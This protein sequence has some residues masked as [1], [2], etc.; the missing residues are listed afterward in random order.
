M[1]PTQEDTTKEK[2]KLPKKH[3]FGLS[4]DEILSLKIT[5]IMTVITFFLLY[6]FLSAKSEL[7]IA[8]TAGAIGG[9]LHEFVQSKGKVL[10]IQQMEDGL[11]LGS[12]SGLILGMVAGM[13][14]YAGTVSPNIL[15]GTTTNLNS[16]ATTQIV[17]S[18]SQGMQFL[19]F[20]SMLA[21]LALK[22]VSEAA[23]SPAKVTD[24]FKIISAE[25]LSHDKKQEKIKVVIKNHASYIVQLQHIT[26]TDAENH[27]QSMD[28]SKE[29][30]KA[31]QT[32]SLEVPCSWR[33][34]V[35]YTITI[36]SLNGQDELPDVKSPA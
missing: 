25:F 19:L 2:E 10:F 29:S 30:V 23:T 9:F 12:I 8:L 27:T 6:V 33:N 3:A 22:G 28:I 18:V 21:G 15:T 16:T 32:L 24:T 34:N 31:K 7:G 36:I 20:E 1:L 11:Y 26:I 14:V 5:I 17:P 35:S 4:D 13:L